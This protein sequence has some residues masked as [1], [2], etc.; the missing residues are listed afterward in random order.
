MSAWAQTVTGRAL[1]YEEPVFTAEHLFTEIGH[2]L[3]LIARFAGQTDI[4]YSVA[5]HSVLMAESALDET[6]DGEL[7]AHCLLH[8]GHEALIG[9]RP[10]PMADAVAHEARIRCAARFASQAAAAVVVAVFQDA[11]AR[12][13]ARLDA[14]IWQSA[15]LDEPTSRIAALV[16]SYDL[17]ALATEKRDLMRPA[18]RTW[19]ERIEASPPLRLRQGRIRPWPPAIA[20]ERFAAALTALCPD[21]AKAAG[22]TLS[23]GAA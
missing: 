18:P 8:D 9:D 15:G 14:A 1:D 11:E 4:A 10:K 12:V 21:A 2:G 6:G 17:R 7:A 5:Q 22:R 3:S 19:N 23:E 20:E 13:K 16:K